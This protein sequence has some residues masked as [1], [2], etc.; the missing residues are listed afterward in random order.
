MRAVSNLAHKWAEGGRIV[1]ERPRR[2]S[3]GFDHD[4]EDARG[5]VRISTSPDDM[6]GWAEVTTKARATIALGK[7]RETFNIHPEIAPA[8]ITSLEWMEILE[9]AD[10]F[11]EPIWLALFAIQ[12]ANP[13]PDDF[14]D[15]AY[16][17]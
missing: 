4:F 9:V 16:W 12:V 8:M 6:K 3:G 15:D 1:D 5:V 13:I 14:I 11:R 17:P 10:A 7:S 2:L